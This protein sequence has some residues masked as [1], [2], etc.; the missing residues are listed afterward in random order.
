ML[1]LNTW[2][3]HA[4]A[5]CLLSLT[6]LVGC[7]STSSKYQG[8]W[9]Q[10][11]RPSAVEIRQANNEIQWITDSTSMPLEERD[12]SLYVKGYGNAMQMTL[13]DSGDTLAVTTKTY[14]G[15]LRTQRYLKD[16]ERVKASH[17]QEA[18]KY[19]LR[20]LDLS[21]YKQIQL[22]N[23]AEDCKRVGSLFSDSDN[24]VESYVQSNGITCTA[25]SSDPYGGG[26][27]VQLNLA[28]PEDTLTAGSN[29][30]LDASEVVGTWKE[31]EYNFNPLSF[32]ISQQPDG[33]LA[34]DLNGR[35]FVKNGSIRHR[36]LIEFDKPS[37]D[38]GQSKY[39]VFYLPTLN[40]MYLES[41]GEA[42]DGSFL[43]EMRR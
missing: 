18:E 20:I 37:E 22:R 43:R 31:A 38:Y 42:T 12:G 24:D 17:R 36:F 32:T 34:G 26:A 9:Y 30:K 4:T 5:L 3:F 13:E 41:S 11:E 16:I 14:G 27:Q 1:K 10:L 28:T 15:E 7:Q 19:L 33:L 25:T 6:T 8:K 23:F 35:V 29:Q 21:V 39:R 40:K 2:T